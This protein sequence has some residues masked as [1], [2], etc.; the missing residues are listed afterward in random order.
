MFFKK[1]NLF[2]FKESGRKGGRKRGTETSIVIGA[3]MN[4]GERQERVIKE[5]V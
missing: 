2:I 3:A 4:I 5:H 1:I